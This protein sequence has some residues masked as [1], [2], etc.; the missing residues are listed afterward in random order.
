ML[1]WWVQRICKS[2]LT[3]LFW[4]VLKRGDFFF[5]KLMTWSSMKYLSKLEKVLLVQLFLWD[6]NM[7]RKSKKW[8]LPWLFFCFLKLWC[9]RSYVSLLGMLFL[10][11][12]FDYV[13]MCW[14]RL[15]LPAKRS[16]LA[17]LLTRRFVLLSRDWISELT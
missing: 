6:I 16:G 8:S 15:D 14:R 10:M 5:T 9:M 1:C 4:F 13:D 3:Q 7:R 2:W 17:D 11:M 12:G